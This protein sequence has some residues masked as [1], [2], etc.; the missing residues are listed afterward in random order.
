MLTNRYRT[1]SGRLC[2]F[3]PVES[4]EHAQNFPPDGTD[5]PDI[6]EIGADPPDRKR[7]QSGYERTRT[8]EMMFYPLLVQ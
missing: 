7:T 6:V 4:F 5:I 3:C 1:S 2:T 8:D